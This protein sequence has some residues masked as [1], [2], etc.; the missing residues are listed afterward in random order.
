M[1][2][3]V[4]FTFYIFD[5]GDVGWWSRYIAGLREC[6]RACD[7]NF[8]GYTIALML[9][10]D[11]EDG[12]R[13]A[14]PKWAKILSAV[15]DHAS[16][17]VHR[18]KMERIAS[19]GDKNAYMTP[20][21]ARY[22][23]LDHYRDA[24][25]VAIRDADSPPTQADAAAV[26]TWRRECAAKKPMLSYALTLWGADRVGGGMTFHKPGT[27]CNTSILKYPHRI[28]LLLE[29]Q[30][31]NGWGIDE[32]VSDD[33]TP[34]KDVWCLVD[35]FHDPDVFVYYTALDFRIPLIDRL[36]AR[37]SADCYYAI[38][39]GECRSVPSRHGAKRVWECACEKKCLEDDVPTI[40]AAATPRKDR[41]VLYEDTPERGVA[42]GVYTPVRTHPSPSRVRRLLSTK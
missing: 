31:G 24:E 6:V 34:S 27:H 15:V 4:S 21:Y 25:V 3:V 38:A 14:Y 5:W 20:L 42:R 10:D 35:C 11:V 18:F 28:K 1:A 8:P 13:K 30:K 29:A 7:H 17:A 36:D 9:A 16:V 22:L 23:V 33:I 2:K 26:E 12:L 40:A 32:V 41:L 39:T 37:C 19:H